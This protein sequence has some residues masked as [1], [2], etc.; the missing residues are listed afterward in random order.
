MKKSL[1]AVAALMTLFLT[2]CGETKKEPSASAP[3]SEASVTAA[4]TPVEAFPE[5]SIFALSLYD[6]D[7]ANTLIAIGYQSRKMAAI[8]SF[9][10]NK[11]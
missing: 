4:S 7:E 10:S 2:A 6:L 3:A 1:L 5:N 8:K 9:L 11:K